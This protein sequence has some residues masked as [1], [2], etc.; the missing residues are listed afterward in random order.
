M[1]IRRFL[2]VMFLAAWPGAALAQGVDIEP[3]VQYR[4]ET[5]LRALEYGVSFVLPAE[6]A[7]VL[8]PDAEMFVM[9]G[10]TFEAYILAGIEEMTLAEAQGLMAEEIDVGDGIV[11]HPAGAVTTDGSLLVADYSVT[12]AANPLIGQVVTIIG[13]H[14]FGIYFVAATEPD[15]RER[16]REAVTRISASVKLTDP[17]PAATEPEA[18]DVGGW[19]QQLRGKKL[20]Y[21]YTRTGYT[22]EDYLWLCAD[23]RF[24]RSANSGGFGGGASGAF[25][26]QY[27]GRWQA[28]GDAA[29]GTL[30]LAYND[31]STASYALSIEEEKLYLDGSRYFREVTDC[32]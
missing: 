5:T 7:G 24:Y 2:S 19:E 11:L 26:S 10:L 9:Q 23:G 16:L 14:G 6:W 4:G 15:N 20:S 27:G 29:G 21:F 8:P 13:D 28:T 22:E 3:G 25:A 1:M 17:V 18:G 31:G 30:R 32:R 12:G